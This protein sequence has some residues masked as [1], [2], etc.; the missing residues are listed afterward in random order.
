[1]RDI[2]L[3]SDP[4]HIQ[5]GVQKLC[6]VVDWPAG[7][8]KPYRCYLGHFLRPPSPIRCLR[9]SRYRAYHDF[10]REYF[11]RILDLAC[12]QGRSWKG[13]HHHLVLATAAY[14]FI[15]SMEL[16]KRRPFW[17]CTREDGPVD[18]SI[19]EE[20]ARFASILLRSGNPAGHD[21]LENHGELRASS[22]A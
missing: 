1:M 4:Y 10:Y 8:A 7:D 22:V 19:A 12:Y 20:T 11:D 5:E 16:R 9:L 17:P 3:D 14:L 21:E 18:Q 6:L 15:L 13:F 2:C